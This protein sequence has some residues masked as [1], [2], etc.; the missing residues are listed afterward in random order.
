[1]VEPVK[2]IF[3]NEYVGELHSKNGVFKLGDQPGGLNPYD[4][5]LGA[6]GA[7]FYA[8]FIAIVNK[9]RLTFAGATIDISG[10][11]REEEPA[12]LKTVLINL[13]INNGSNEAQFRRSVELAAKYC[14]VHETIKKVAEITIIIKFI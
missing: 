12:T 1:M 9:K 14:S 13:E 7:C 8:T 11:K 2:L 3:T 6:L 10:E 4:M 5:M